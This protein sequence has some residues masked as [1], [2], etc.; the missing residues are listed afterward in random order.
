MSMGSS[1]IS[2]WKYPAHTDQNNTGNA[3]NALVQNW[4]I[5]YFWHMIKHQ[6]QRQIANKSA[7]QTTRKHCHPHQSRR[8][9]QQKQRS[10]KEPYLTSG[11]RHWSDSPFLEK[12]WQ[13]VNRVGS[14][15]PQASVLTPFLVKKS[16][17]NHR[18]WIISKRHR[19]GVCHYGGFRYAIYYDGA[20]HIVFSYN[21]QDEKPPW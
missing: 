11:Y 16:K 2:L 12:I 10:S 14:F 7:F 1:I 4:W 9:K 3:V 5:K 18:I 6:R 21:Q 20:F 15:V 17:I 8:Y 13:A 19:D